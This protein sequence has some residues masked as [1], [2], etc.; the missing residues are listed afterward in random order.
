[1]EE[2]VK[3]LIGANSPSDILDDIEFVSKI[4]SRSWAV[5]MLLIFERFEERPESRIE[6][7]V[8]D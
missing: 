2:G 7:K 5:I 3:A 4:S 1:M 6:A 8:N